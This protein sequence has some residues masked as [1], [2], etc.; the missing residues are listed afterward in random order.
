MEIEKPKMTFKAVDTETPSVIETEAKAVAKAEEAAAENLHAATE[1]PAVVVTEESKSQVEITDDVVLGYV[2]SKYK[3]DNLSSLDEIFAAKQEEV[4]PEDVVAYAKYK[5]DTG[6]GMDDFLKLQRDVDTISEEALLREYLLTKEEGLEA[7]DIESIIETEYS[8]D[9]DLDDPK[10]IAAI[11]R[12]YKK[13]LNEA[14]KYFNEQK[15]QY[16]APLE[17]KAASVPNEEL[18]QFNAYKE[19]LKQAE[20]EQ[21]VITRQAQNFEEKTNKVFSDEFKGFKFKINE[22]EVVVPFGDPNEL[23]NLHSTPRNFINKYL[24]KET[25]MLVDAEGYHRALAAAMNPEKLATFF[26]ELGKAEAIESTDKEI[27]NINMTQRSVPQSVGAKGMRF[28]VVP[29]KS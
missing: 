3:K 1:T 26:Y 18:D 17:S 23:K 21:E 2:K 29:D 12:K 20:T 13:T 27:K 4:L 11:K 14:K 16:K 6:R 22:K 28:R 19:Y 9:E 5:K 24:D 25:G 7:E 8:Y 10:D 15:E